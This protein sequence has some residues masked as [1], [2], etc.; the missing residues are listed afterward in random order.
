MNRPIIATLTVALLVAAAA[1]IYAVRTTGQE[2]P[3]RPTAP[4]ATPDA[5]FTTDA[6]AAREELTAIDARLG[7][8]IDAVYAADIEAV[9]ALVDWRQET[10]GLR[11][12]V[13]CGNAVEGGTVAVVNVEG[14]GPPFFVSAEVLRPS[15]QQALSGSPLELR[16]A[17]QS[18]RQPSVYT[19]GFDGAEVK[20]KGLEP[21]A[22]PASNITGLFLTLDLSRELP[23]IQI[24]QVT[25][26]Y[27]ATQRGSEFG[28]QGQ[29]V[30]VF[31]PVTAASREE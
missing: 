27:R 24:E 21:L 16:F 17:A 28:L 7:A 11:R 8:V 6:R 30:I 15:L 18:L 31:A 5:P 20:G 22:D 25:D 9:F 23:L 13:H 4:A 14:V 26:D 1:G 2:S 19:L 29:R 12:D 10:C 3:E